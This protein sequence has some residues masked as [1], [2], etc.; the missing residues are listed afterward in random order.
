M[1]NQNKDKT[2]FI[3]E[4][5]YYLPSAIYGCTSPR[6]PEAASTIFLFL[7][8]IEETS[9]L[10]SEGVDSLAAKR[11]AVKIGFDTSVLRPTASLIE[12]FSMFSIVNI[13]NDGT[14]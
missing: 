2:E 13:K 7:T 11:F 3:H 4:N 6:V 12:V 5:Y 14:S 10:I 8:T 9:L 1:F